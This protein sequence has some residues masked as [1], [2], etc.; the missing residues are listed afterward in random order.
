M[1]MTAA[2]W[3]F[4]SEQ[5]A[6]ATMRAEQASGRSWALSGIAVR[7]IHAGSPSG[8]AWV[9]AARRAHRLAIYWRAYAVAAVE[10]A[11]LPEGFA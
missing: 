1:S 7:R 10:V 6:I 8:P 5:E 11:T 4:C 3:D 2:E 9:G